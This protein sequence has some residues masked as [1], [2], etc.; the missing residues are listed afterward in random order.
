MRTY[1][2]RLAAAAAFMF[3][4]NTA[5]AQDKIRIGL[6]YTLAG[7]ASAL[8]HPHLPRDAGA[9]G[10]RAGVR[11]RGRLAADLLLARAG[12]R[13]VPARPGPR[14]FGVA[15]EKREASA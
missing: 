5:A 7:P 2:C 3:V 9:E 15:G 8:G 4:V 10:R 13:G 6:I 12:A 11:D 14:R 1:V